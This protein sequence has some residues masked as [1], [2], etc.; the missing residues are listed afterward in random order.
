MCA[1]MVKK[2]RYF[3]K[4][5]LTNKIERFPFSFQNKYQKTENHNFIKIVSKKKQIKICFYPAHQ[6]SIAKRGHFAKIV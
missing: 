5:N 3:Q 4:T 2:Q 1:K 6:G